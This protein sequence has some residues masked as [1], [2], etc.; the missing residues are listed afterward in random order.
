[1]K[2]VYKSFVDEYP[3]FWIEDLFDHDEWVHYAE[4]NEEIGEQVQIV[5]GDVAQ[6]ALWRELAT[7]CGRR[8]RGGIM[9]FWPSHPGRRG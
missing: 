5:G 2:N 9:P 4:M 1:M 3:I 7:A 8:R 6:F